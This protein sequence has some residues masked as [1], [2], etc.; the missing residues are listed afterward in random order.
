MT[1][2]AENLKKE[3]PNQFAPKWTLKVRTLD[4]LSSGRIRPALLVLLGAV[5]FVLLIACANVAN[6]LLARAAIRIKGV[7]IRS[8]LGADRASLVRQLLTE[9]VMLALTGGVLGLVLA[10]WSVK[11]LVALNPEPS[12]RVGDRDRR[13]R[14]GVHALRVGRHGLAVRARAGAADVA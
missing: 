5:G 1:T 4:D 2:F 13:Q 10:Q 3:Y 11:S 6:L 8:A 12:A 9:S 14:D 7:A